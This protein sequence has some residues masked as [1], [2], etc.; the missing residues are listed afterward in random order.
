MKILMNSLYTNIAEAKAFELRFTNMIYVYDDL[1][2][3]DFTT[4][5]CKRCNRVEQIKPFLIPQSNCKKPCGILDYGD[6]G[7]SQELR[8]ELIARFDITEDDFRPVY[9]KR[10]KIVYYQI[11][12]QHIMLPINKVNH[13]NP[14]PDCE[15]CGSKRFSHRDYEN[16]KGEFFHYITQEA[17]EDMRDL[18]VT[19]EC[20][21]SHKPLTVISRRVYD[22]LT[23]RYPRTHYYPFF[24][25][26]KENEE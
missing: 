22:Y 13:W 16:D 26:S 25:R 8:D 21:S 14:Y 19:Y 11:T 12:P 6:H 15:L 20:F 10:G 4:K 5:P 7:V 2:L 24:L 3:F 23:E 17:L 1:C 9:N 18:N